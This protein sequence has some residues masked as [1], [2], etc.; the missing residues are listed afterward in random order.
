MDT[1]YKLS[2][3]GNDFIVLDGR[4]G[5][6]DEY[7]KAG[8][9]QTLCDRT[10]GFKAADGRIGADGVMILSMAEEAGWDFVMEYFNSDGSSGMMCGNGGRC[11]VA[12]ADYLGIV[13]ANGKV[14]EFLAA[15]GPHTGEILGRK[16]TGC[17]VKLKMKDVS[18]FRRCTDGW[19]LDTG[20]R[21]FVKFVEDVETVDISTEGPR[22][23]WSDE[24]APIGANVNFVQPLA[25]G[26]LKVRTFEKGVEDETLACGTG[27]T[28]SALAACLEKTDG[29]IPAWTD[30]FNLQSIHTDIHARIDELAVDFIPAGSTFVDVYLTGPA[31]LV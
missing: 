11:I 7:R 10:S 28:A 13:P 1:L 22:Y 20:T 9:I 17:T 2:G 12:F 4:G 14:Y 29:K 30:G 6:M 31:T 24:F 18:E 3:A 19:F 5:G 8:T 26:S 16:G 15:D 25:D 27:I 21:H 23:R